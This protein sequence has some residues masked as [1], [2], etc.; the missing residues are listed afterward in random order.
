MLCAG[1]SW[2][3]KQFFMYFAINMALKPGAENGSTILIILSV[4]FVVN[5]LF[6]IIVDIGI[7]SLQLPGQASSLL[8]EA[9]VDAMLQF[10]ADEEDR[11]D[12]GT[13]VNTIGSRV[14]VVVSDAW[15]Q[16]FKLWESIWQTLCMLAIIVFSVSELSGLIYGVVLLVIN[17]LVF[18]W[19][20]DRAL[21]LDAA[22]Q[23]EE[24]DWDQDE[25]E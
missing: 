11:L 3:V 20:K 9:C 25:E 24:E 19:R 13:V 10:T 6:D 17:V 4:A 22:A 14:Q 21:E 5:T 8:R 1:I 16:T 23:K 7:R 15:M 12:V 18:I 2:S